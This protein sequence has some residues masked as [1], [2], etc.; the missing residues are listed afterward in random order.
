MEGLVC[1]GRALDLSQEVG[2]SW[3]V[4]AFP[5]ESALVHWMATGPLLI[6][7]AFPSKQTQF[8]GTWI[9]ISS[10]PTY[11]GSI[12]ALLELLSLSSFFPSLCPQD[13]FS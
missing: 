13:L 10:P 3:R 8:C 12:T 5:S 4:F 11:M 7:M 2:A 1:Q 9:V 6:F